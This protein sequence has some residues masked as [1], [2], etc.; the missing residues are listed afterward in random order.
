MKLPYS[1]TEDIIAKVRSIPKDRIVD[2]KNEL[3][4][5]EP[6]LFK[7]AKDSVKEEIRELR[8]SGVQMQSEDSV[9]YAGSIILQA[10]IEGF[11][12]GLMSSDRE[13]SNHFLLDDQSTDTPYVRPVNALLEGQLD[14][15]YYDQIVKTMTD[16]ERKDSTH[17]KNRALTAHKEYVQKQA[18]L[19]KAA[20]FFNNDDNVPP[21][22]S[23][24]GPTPNVDIT[25]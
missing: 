3:Q 13:W 23:S 17:W 7:W 14:K 15:K 16:E 2:M 12:I 18:A 20:S 22:K 1:V 8:Y 11:L 4:V 19:N 5:A 24:V 10:K 25:P 9:K 6:V 21:F